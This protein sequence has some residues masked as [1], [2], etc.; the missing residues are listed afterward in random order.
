[1]TT[2]Y[3]K[4]VRCACGCGR[5]VQPKTPGRAAVYVHGHNPTSHPT[6]PLAERFWN[7]VEICAPDECWPWTGAHG[8]DGRGRVWLDGRNIPAPRAALI[9]AGVQYRAGAFACHHCDN[10]PCVNPSHLYFGTPGD[11]VRDMD[12]RGRRVK[13]GALPS[14][15]GELNHHA[16]LSDSDVTAIRRAFTGRRGEQSALARQYGVTPQLIHLIVRGGHRA[17]V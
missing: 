3:F 10:P 12:D 14:M 6:A 1:M 2:T 8:R 5:E 7:R 4:A 16:K 15:A 13:H 11:N 9:L 17:A